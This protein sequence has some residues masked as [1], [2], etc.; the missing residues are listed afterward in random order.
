MIGAIWRGD[1]EDED[2]ENSCLWVCTYPKD[3]ARRVVDGKFVDADSNLTTNTQRLIRN[4]RFLLCVL[5]Q[6][7]PSGLRL[8]STARLNPYPYRENYDPV[9]IMI[10]PVPWSEVKA[11][12]PWDVLDALTLDEYSKRFLSL[13]IEPLTIAKDDFGRWCD[14]HDQERPAFW[15]GDV[16]AEDQQ[17]T[18]DANIGSAA[19]H[20]LAS[21]ADAVKLRG[22]LKQWIENKAAK[23]N[24]EEYT[25]ADFLTD[26]RY[27]L[28]KNISEDMF[29]QVWKNSIVPIAIRKGGRRP[30]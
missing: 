25:K 27:D 24:P 17:E 15:F 12:V 14:D 13:H 23:E 16:A 9:G 30:G 5:A 10:D 8:P 18:E 4:R 7:R 19:A 2:G 6:D 22:L 29:K 26:A 20:D 21:H 3:G 11:E 1:F 28:K